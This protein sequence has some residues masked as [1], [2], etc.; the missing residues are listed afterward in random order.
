MPPS[1]GTPPLSWSLSPL[2]S[3]WLLISISSL[4]FLGLRLGF[5]TSPACIPDTSNSCPKLL[6]ISSPI[7]LL[8]FPWRYHLMPETGWSPSACDGPREAKST[9]DISVC[10]QTDWEDGFLLTG[11][12][13]KSRA[14]TLHS[15]GKMLRSWGCWFPGAGREGRWRFP[16]VS[17]KCLCT[18]QIA[19]LGYRNESS[20][21]FLKSLSCG[22]T[23]IILFLR[24]KTLWSIRLWKTDR[25][26]EE[27]EH[28]EGGAVG[29]KLLWP[30]KGRVGPV[31]TFVVGPFLES[32]WI[33][34]FFLLLSLTKFLPS[35]PTL[36]L[37]CLVFF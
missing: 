17:W 36:S 8:I 13:K 11:E 33:Y 35:L 5:S 26:E 1:P 16:A 32:S 29:R 21:A 27:K 10:N 3:L 23:G 7:P 30:V 4:D 18:W 34:T 14:G 15:G 20:R 37:S 25:R 12:K 22:L 2:T 28:W 19:D 24:A 6:L 31:T 9:Y